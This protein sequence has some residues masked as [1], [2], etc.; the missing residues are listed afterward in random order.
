M[1]LLIRPEFDIALLEE[2]IGQQSKKDANGRRSFTQDLLY[3]RMTITANVPSDPARIR[4][5]S[6][7]R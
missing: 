2:E 6:N 7:V 4:L 1:C 5:R 3:A